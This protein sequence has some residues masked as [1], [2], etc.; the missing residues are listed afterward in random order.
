RGDTRAQGGE[1]DE[2]WRKKKIRWWGGLWSC[3]RR[4]ERGW[5]KGEGEVEKIGRGERRRGRVRDEGG[6]CWRREECGKRRWEGGRGRIGR[7]R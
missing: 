4:R 1:C 2:G 6:W 3:E 7:R 5:R